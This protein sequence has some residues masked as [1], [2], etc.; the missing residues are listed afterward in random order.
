MTLLIAQSRRCQTGL[1]IWLLLCLPQWTLAQKRPGGNKRA[2]STTTTEQTWMPDN[3]NGTFTNPLFYDEFSDPDL[4]RVGEDYYLTGTTMHA[5]PGLPV[6]HSKDLVN[7]ELL[8]YASDKLDFGPEYRLE[9]GKSVY[10]QGIWAPSFRYAN[11]KFHIFTNV[12]GRKTQLYTATNPAGPWTHT[13]L[14]KSF[15]DLSV[16]FDDD[17]KTYVIWG[18]DELKIAELT[19]DLSDTKPGTEQ[20]LIP[21]GSGVGEG[22]HFYKINGKYFI[23]NTNYDPV[24]YMVCA[25]AD[26]ATGP[27]E[28]TVISAEEA[29]GIGVTW[30]LRPGPNPPFVLTPPQND[31]SSAIPLHQGGIV[32]TPTGEWWGF[33]MMDHNA[34]GRLLCLSPVTWTNNWPYFGLP[35]NLKRSPRTWVKPTSAAASAPSAPFKRNDEFNANQ[36]NPLWQWNHLPENSKWSLTERKG[37]LR[38]HA[39]PAKD[40]WSARNSLTQ[41]AIGPEST[42]TTELDTKG[43]KPGDVAG[44][45]LLNYPYAW[46]GVA[47]TAAG[48]EVQQY[49]QRTD[50][51]QRQP[52]KAARVWLRAPCDFDNDLAR[53]QYSTDGVTFQTMGEE[54]KLVFQLRTFQG[55]RYALFNYNTTGTAGGYADFNRFVV[56]Q[57]RSKGLTKPIPMGQ[58]ITLTSLADSTI[59]INWRGSLRP[60]PLKHPLAKGTASH[61]RVID[62]GQGRIA[63]ESAGGQESDGGLVTVVGMAGM[64]EV[65]IMKG[66]SNDANTFQWQD[67]LRGDLMLM[68]LT[69]H[70]Y[71]TAQPRSSGLCAADAPGTRPDRQD[72]SCFRWQ[73]VTVK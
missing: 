6:L 18:Y 9:N 3:G 30:R 10:G 48:L 51:L 45:A 32:Q 41:R 59:L 21:R 67:M 23:T 4:I 53:V 68:A 71:L 64:G 66:E 31:F 43:L 47:R 34:V 1:L 62:R 25:R 17:G 55:I 38:L 40:F 39:L 37:Y 12:N 11:G 58:T 13:E 27:Y 70:R 14:K 73:A 19:D 33:S 7:W 44:L 60:V 56:D 35:G 36:L 24:G 63:L 57:P 26:K 50:K 8:S 2:T 54:I 15:H 49:D 28:T 72:G 22:S 16:L 42:P 20:V 52:I 46:I 65:R 61:F 69:N 29:L 5:M